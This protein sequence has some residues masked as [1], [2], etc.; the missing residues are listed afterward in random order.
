MNADNWDNKLTFRFEVLKTSYQDDVSIPL[1]DVIRLDRNNIGNFTQTGDTCFRFSQLV[2]QV[3]HYFDCLPEQS[4]YNLQI[5]S[6]KSEN[7]RCYIIPVA[8]A[9]QPNDWTDHI[10]E[11]SIFEYIN[12]VFLTDLQNKKSMLLIDQSV[13]GYH[14]AWLW[15]WFHKKCSLYNI[16]PQAI[17]YV[18]GD[19]S[20]L[21]NYESWANKNNVDARINIIPSTTLS[22]YIYKTYISRKLDI[23]FDKLLTYKKENSDNLYLYDCINFRPRPQRIY[24][25]LHLKNLRLLDYGNISVGDHPNWSINLSSQQLKKYRLPADIDTRIPPKK[26]NQVNP[27]SSDRYWEFVE[28]I[29]DNVYQN[30][31]VSIITESSYFKYESS[32]FIS[33]KTFKPIS[34]MQPFIIVGSK[35]SLKYLRKLGY[36]TFDGFIDESYDNLDDED[37]FFAIALAIQKIKNIEDKAAWYESMRPIL[38]HNHK[39]F[40]SIGIAHSTDVNLLTKYYSNYFKK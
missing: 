22:F 19:Q 39:L 9:Y 27:T 10:K 33:E 34:C 6:I 20:S 12:P 4:E 18:T 14:T 28:R 13:E 25:Y 8:V 30:S 24:N 17:I 31:W 3:F 23:T 29:L 37:R 1:F 26:I 36:K 15:E 32:V 38:E 11:K 21:D 2:D 35:N 7:D 16:N 5:E 40:L